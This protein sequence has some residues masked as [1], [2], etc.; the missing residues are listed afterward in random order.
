LATSSR[1]VK[2]HPQKQPFLSILGFVFPRTSW[3]GLRNPYIRVK[4]P[5]LQKECQ[6]ARFGI[7]FLRLFG[8]FYS[9][10]E[11]FWDAWGALGRIWEHVGGIGEPW[12]AFWKAFGEQ[13]PSW[14]AF[15]G[16]QILASAEY[17]AHA[18]AAALPRRAALGLNGIYWHAN[19]GGIYK[20]SLRSHCSTR[21]APARG[22]PD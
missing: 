13:K 20:D 15:W 9:L 5:L 22:A 16:E 11:P 21:R 7:P 18:A 8:S 12:G 3:F 4:R 6:K 17:A 1:N 10:V 2:K 19:W 14:E